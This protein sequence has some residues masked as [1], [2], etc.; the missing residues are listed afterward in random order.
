[1]SKPSK[2]EIEEIISRTLPIKHLTEEQKQ[3]HIAKQARDKVIDE[4]NE[5][6]LISTRPKRKE[7]SQESL[8]L[9]SKLEDAF[10]S[11]GRRTPLDRNK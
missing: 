1:M 2:K 10:L 11:G 7:A 5:I 6:R 9:K 4:E 3:E 8:D